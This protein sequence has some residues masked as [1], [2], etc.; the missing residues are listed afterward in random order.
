M[1]A[2]VATLFKILLIKELKQI[3]EQ[4]GQVLNITIII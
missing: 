3:P 2:G 4:R 1:C